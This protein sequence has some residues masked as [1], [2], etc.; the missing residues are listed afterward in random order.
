MD[1]VVLGAMVK[2]NPNCRVYGGYFISKL[3]LVKV[4][5]KLI[6]GSALVSMVLA[7]AG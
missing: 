2:I 3:V 1:V 7:K 4:Q 5:G 6:Q